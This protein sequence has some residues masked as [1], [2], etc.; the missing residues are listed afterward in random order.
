MRQNSTRGM[1]RRR[2]KMEEE[3]SRGENRGLGEAKETGGQSPILN[4][5]Q[6]S[7][8]LTTIQFRGHR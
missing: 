3:R 1:G 4:T 5:S 2:E 8:H 6:L 7:S